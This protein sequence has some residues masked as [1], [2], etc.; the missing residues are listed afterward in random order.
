MRIARRADWISE[1]PRDARSAIEARFQYRDVNSGEVIGETGHPCE[2]IYQVQSGYVKLLADHADGERSLLA[3]YMPG[4]CFCESPVI[5]CRPHNHTTI[6]AGLTRIG[7]LKKADFDE[8]Y[9]RFPSIPEALCRKF[10]SAQSSLISYR[11]TQNQTTVGQRVAMVLHNLA[12]ISQTPQ[13]DQYKEIDVPITISE[14]STYLGLTRQTIQKEISQLKKRNLI[15]KLPGNWAV[16]EMSI[17]A[18]LAN[19]NERQLHY[20]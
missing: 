3:V 17:L 6:A 10:A 1:L 12:Q 18:S 15:V 9:N 19:A 11:E 20:S 5:A 4:N 14:M 13:I 2:G 8:L 16:R 7:V